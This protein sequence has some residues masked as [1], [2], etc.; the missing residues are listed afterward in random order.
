MGEELRK[1]RRR[2]PQTHR[3]S[4][5]EPWGGRHAQDGLDQLSTDRPRLSARTARRSLHSGR[6]PRGKMVCKSRAGRPIVPHG[7]EQSRQGLSAPGRCC[8]LGQ[9]S[10]MCLWLKRG[11]LGRQS[12]SGKEASR[13][14]HPRW[15]VHTRCPGGPSNRQRGVGGRGGGTGM[16]E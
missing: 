2:T 7:H 9:A 4:V 13:G 6:H 5:G 1:L 10:K 8:P 15:P 16:T 14:L 12:S 3:W 11:S